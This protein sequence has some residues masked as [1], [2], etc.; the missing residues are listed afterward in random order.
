M[1]LAVLDIIS[2]NPELDQPHVFLSLTHLAPGWISSGFCNVVRCD[3]YR[4]RTYLWYH[5]LPRQ[6]SINQGTDGSMSD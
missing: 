5:I 2:V 1:Y 4:W 6:L 3:N